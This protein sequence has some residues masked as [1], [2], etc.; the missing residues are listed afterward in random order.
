MVVQKNKVAKKSIRKRWSF[1]EKLCSE[2]VYG[3]D[4]GEAIK[5]VRGCYF[6]HSG[7]LSYIVV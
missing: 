3:R 2:K 6:I 1:K 7:S 4:D 5:L